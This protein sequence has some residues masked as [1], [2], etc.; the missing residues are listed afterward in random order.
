MAR[1]GLPEF[2]VWGSWE[3]KRQDKNMNVRIIR[4]KEVIREQ[5]EWRELKAH[6]SEKACG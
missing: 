5:P 3:V 6:T 1:E 2:F 4:M